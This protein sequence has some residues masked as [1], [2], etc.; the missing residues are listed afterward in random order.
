MYWHVVAAAM[1]IERQALAEARAT[2]TEATESRSETSGTD[3]SSALEHAH[4]TEVAILN[5]L[6]MLKDKKIEFLNLELDKKEA[7]RQQEEV[8]GRTQVL[9]LSCSLCSYAIAL[10]CDD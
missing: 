1:E 7:R 9:L 2:S 5:R 6:L 10:A 8:A 4:A 3:P